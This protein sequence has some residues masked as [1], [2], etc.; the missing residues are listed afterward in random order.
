MSDH[1]GFSSDTS[2]Y[3]C[4]MS[5]QFPQRLLVSY[6]TTVAFPCVVIVFNS[7]ML[8]LVVFK[9]LQLRRGGA[10]SGDWK[11]VTREKATRLWKECVTVVGLSCM[12][13]LPWGLAS[14]T[15]MSVP[16]IYIF[17]ILN[18]LQGQIVPD[19]R[20]EY[21]QF[22]CLLEDITVFSLPSGVFMFLWSVALTCKSRHDNNSSSRDPSS[23]KMIM[24]SFNS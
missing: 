3:R 8:G 14:T 1:F 18:S 21:I 2:S 4:W 20:T 6:V 23:Q 7:C 19:P 9:L 13:G 10:G 16:G 5:S 11:Q 12:L 24:T 22:L 15:Y 17:T